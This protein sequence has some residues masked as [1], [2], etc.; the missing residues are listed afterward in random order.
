[1]NHSPAPIKI[2]DR[3]TGKILTESVMGS[4]A[5]NFAYNTLLGRSLWGLLFSTGFLSR[6]MG[7]FYDSKYSRSAI[8]SL[9]QIPGLKAEEA[10]FP[11][12]KY[13]SFND[14][15]T[16]RLKPGSR[17]VAE[18]KNIL[19]SP[20]DGRLLIYPEISP[21]VGFPVKG[22]KRSLNML[23]Q[24]QLPAEKYSVAVVRLAPIDYHR[25]HYPCDCTECGKMVK[26][27]GKYHS[28]N[29]VAFAKAPDLFVE[30]TR[31]I[32]MLDSPFFGKFAYLEIGAF[33]V[34]SIVNT[35]ESSQHAKMDE[36]GFF[37]FGGSTVILVMEAGKV[38]FDADLVHNSSR[39]METLIRCGEKIGTGV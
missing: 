26:I 5:L 4:K 9:L 8:N 14:F 18:G 39:N 24:C 10:E 7:S 13:T 37:K 17:P 2:V 3:A 11:P 27:A 29:P 6:L 20:A 35:S 23:C 21:T 38:A 33:G 30:N 16:R 36:K 12:E 19:I 31:C 28:V 15:F 1:M 34:G 32:T 22:A 25:Y